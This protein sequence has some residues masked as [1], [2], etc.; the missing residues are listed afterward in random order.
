MH[1]A[2]IGHG[3][4]RGTQSLTEHLATKDKAPAE[5]LALTAKE[6]LFDA[7]EAE[8]GD[9]LVENGAHDFSS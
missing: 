4:R 6:V 5:V 9:E 8:Q 2:V 1:G 3:L 7:L